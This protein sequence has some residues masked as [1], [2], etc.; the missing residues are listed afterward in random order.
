MAAARWRTR[1]ASV[2]TAALVSVGG[3]LVFAQDASTPSSQ[4]A[5]TPAPVATDE[6]PRV[7]MS[8]QE[9]VSKGSDLIGRMKAVLQRVVQLQEAARR[10][11][12]IIKLNCVN[13]KLLQVKQLLNIA[14]GASTNLQE[15]IARQDEDGRYHEFGRIDIA[16]Q[17][18]SMIIGEAEQCVGEELSFLGPT[19]V[20]VEGSEEPEDP[21]AMPEADFPSV[22]AP[23]V[24]TPF[25]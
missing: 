17:Q 4:P 10:K 14:E 12:D 11:K 9:M 13:D 24:A 3:G 22:E 8:P 19:Q 6:A 2:A 20:I 16:H 7:P 1:L 5:K 23:N 15:A 25:I 21:L 18:A